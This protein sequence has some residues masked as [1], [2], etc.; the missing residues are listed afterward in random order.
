MQAGR[1]EMKPERLTEKEG[2]FVLYEQV[3][4]LGGSW[5]LKG[6]RKVKCQVNVTGK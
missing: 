1:S 4:C 5:W 6:Q 3:I 2:G